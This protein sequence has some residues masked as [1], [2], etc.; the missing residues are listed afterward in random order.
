MAVPVVLIAWFAIVG[1]VTL[2]AE[3]TATVVVVAPE[4]AA[5]RAAAASGADLI[6]VTHGFSIM[7]SDRRG[8][9]RNL[10][11]SGV[12][13]VWPAIAGGCLSPPDVAPVRG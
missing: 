2:L 12:W 13:F 10:Y 6:D 5:L 4:A 1:L 7:R 3:P 9:V 11:A 8:F